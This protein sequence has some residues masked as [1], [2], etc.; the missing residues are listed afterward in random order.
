M[1][2]FLIMY[3][4]VFVSLS[5]IFTLKIRKLNILKKIENKVL[6]WFISVIP[7]V[8]I[9]IFMKGDVIN[10]S[11]ILLYSLIILDIISGYLSFCKSVPRYNSIN[12][13][14]GL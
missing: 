5:V 11:I 14:W 7:L 12:F 9:L 1:L 10:V 8:L 2:L 4:I 13:P 6:S 3:A